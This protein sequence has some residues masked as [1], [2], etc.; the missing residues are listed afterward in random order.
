MGQAIAF[1]GL[2]CIVKSAAAQQGRKSITPTEYLHLFSFFAARDDSVAIRVRGTKQTSP[3][4][5]F[6]LVLCRGPWIALA[7]P[8]RATTVRE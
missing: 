8:I 4:T 7:A 2:S 1:C 6:G 5:G 3:L